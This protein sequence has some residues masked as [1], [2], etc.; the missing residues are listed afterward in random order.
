MAIRL[1]LIASLV[2]FLVVSYNSFADTPISG[3]VSGTWT[4][5]KSPYVLTGTVTIPANQTLTIEPGVLVEMPT[6]SQNLDVF[7]TLIAQGTATDSI[8]FRGVGGGG[9]VNSTHG[10]GIFFKAG[11]GAS[12]MQY[13]AIDKLGDNYFGNA[14]INITIPQTPTLQHISV[15]NS[16]QYDVLMW[17]GG[18]NNFADVRSA[19]T[20]ITVG[21]GALDARM[22]KLGP[23][24]F[25]RFINT[26]TVDK[27]YK[28][29]IE[30]GVLVEMPTWSQNLDV[31]G[32]LIAQGTATDSIRFR[33]VGGGGNVNSTHGGGI[34]FKTGGG[35][36]VMQYVAIDK[37]GDNYFGNAAI[38]ITIPQTPTLQHISV[39]NSE[40]YD[41][42]MWV[43]G[44][45][46]FA[47]V[48]SALTGVNNSAGALDARM[49]KLGPNSFY[50]FINTVTVDKGYKLTIEP[51][52]LVEMPTWSQN[53]D[54]FG[55]LIAQGTA[56]DSIRFR[57]VGGGGNVNSTHGGGIY[58]KAG[59]GA[60]VMQYVAIDKLGDNYFGNAAININ[61]A[62]TIR[63]CLIKNAEQ[64]AIIIN[65]ATISPT[66]QGN[67]F[68]ANSIAIRASAGNCNNIFNNTNAVISINNSSLAANA[69]WPIPGYKSY[70]LL[71]GAVTVPQAYI[72]T[73]APG[74][75]VDFGLQGGEIYVNGTLRAIGTESTPIR[76][77]RLQSTTASISGGRIYLSANSTNSALNLINLDKLGS[78]RDNNAALDIATANFSIGNITISN[79]QYR[80]LQLSNV[81]SAVISGSNF[82][83]NK[84][85]VYVSSGRPVFTNCNIYGNSDFGINNVS[86]ATADTVD[87]RNVYWGSELGPFHAS[88]NPTGKGN[89]V[90]NKVKFNPWKR[91]PQNGQIADIGICALV[92]P[93][94]DCNHTSA[95]NVTVR[96]RN[97]GNISQ[98]NFSVSYQI[99][100]GQPVTET[101]SST[102]L[103]PGETLDYTFTQKA[104]LSTIGSYTISTYSSFLADTFRL[105]DTIKVTIQHLPGVVA[106][107]NL[108]PVTNTE[109]LDIPVK[110]SWAAVTGALA[111]DLYVWKADATVPTQ[112]LVSNLSQIAYSLS[113]NNLQYGVAYKW[114]VV[115][116]QVSCRAE[117]AIL[118]F[119]TRL[120]ADLIV[121]S[122]NVP[123]AATSETDIVIRWRVKNQGT[124]ATQDKT[125]LDQVYLCD[126]PVLNTGS[127]NFYVNSISNLRALN[128]G[129]SYPSDELRYRL[130]QGIEGKYY[131]IVQ[132]NASNSVPEANKTNNQLVSSPISVSL[133]PPP[134]LQITSLVT[135]AN[136][137]SDDSTSVTYTIK[138][139]GTGP[140][141]VA[142]WVDQIFL[143]QNQALDVTTDKL[144]FS[145]ERN[146]ALPVNGEYIVS[147]KF[148]MPVRLTTGPYYIHV[149][150]DQLNQVFEY[151]KE[152]N[153]SRTNAINI[154]QKPTPNLVIHGL[155]VPSDT[156][157]TRQPIMVQWTTANEG[158]IATATSWL[159]TIYLSVDTVF[160]T[161][162]DKLL[163]SLLRTNAL[164]SLSSSSTQQSVTIPAST[165]EG[166]YYLF[167]RTDATDQIYES[168]GEQDNVAR[169]S[170]PV[171]VVLPDLIPTLLTAPASATS[172]QTIAVQ[173]KVKNDSRAGIYNT[174]WKDKLYLSTNST[175][176]PATDR[177]LTSVSANQLLAYGSEY[178]KQISTALPTGISGTYFLLLVSDADSNLVEKS[179]T[180]NVR[181]FSF[182][183]TLAPA[184]DL[185]VI[186]IVA[187][188]TDTL[189]TTLTLQYSV[190]NNGT[191]QIDN[192]TWQDSIYLSPTNTLSKANRI[193]LGT[194]YQ[195][196]SLTSGQS[197][198]QSAAFSIPTSISPG[199][200]FVAVKTDADSSIFEN[201]AETNNTTVATTA[202]N[203]V[204]PPSVDLAATAG[205]ILTTNATAGQPIT[206]QW[207]VK[208]NS[209][210][211]TVVSSWQD[212]IY[213]SANPVVD[214]ND[215]LL[216]TVDITKPLAAGTSY[217]RT[218]TVT[219]PPTSTGV[220]YVLIQTDKDNQNFDTQ[221][222]NN[223]LILSNA[224]S[225]GQ[226]ISIITPPPAD[227]VPISLFGPAEGMVSQPVS[228]SFTVRN[229]GTGPTPASNW[230]DQL[231][232]STDLTLGNDIQIGSFPHTGA[233]APGAEYMVTNQ[234]TLP[235]NVSGNYILL[236]K[237]DAGNAVFERNNEDNN[238]A[239]T[240]LAIIP[241]QPSD[242]VVSEVTIPTTERYAGSNSTITWKLSNIGPNAVNG[243]LREAVYLSKDS[244]LDAS[245][246][247]FGT[248]D[249]TV[250]LPSR[251]TQSRMLNKPLAD[252][253][254]GEYVVIVK[255]DVQNNIIEQNESNNEGVSVGK[256]KITVK[257]LVLNTL[258]TDTLIS[259]A[260]LYYRLNIPA[261]LVGETLAITLKGDSVKNA[262]NR[263]F[264]RKD[265]LPTANQY[266][267]LAA[268]P[269]KAN[270]TLI[271]PSLQ[272]GTYYL[273]GLGLDT[274]K[275]RQPV[276]LLARIIPFGISA[277]DAKEGGNTGLVTVKITGARFD[278]TTLFRLRKS[279][280]DLI[281]PYKVQLMDQ[282]LA[283]VTFDLQNKSLGIY[284]VVAEKPGSQTTVLATSFTIKLGPGNSQAANGNGGPAYG[285]GFICNITND[286]LDQQLTADFVTPAAI[287]FAT[288][289]TFT[290][291]FKNEGS[292]DIPVPTRFLIATSEGA[293]LAFT[294]D[295]LSENK[296]DL[297][298]VC[299]EENGPPGILRPGASGYFKIYTVSRTRGIL[300][301]DLLLTE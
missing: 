26:V 223:T 102:A 254:L 232:L 252:V 77:T 108:I 49:P 193:Y 21:A 150:T 199:R 127:D 281:T 202:T 130:P 44:A 272:A 33:G 80:G 4:K 192:K 158:A 35:A 71:I 246:M 233:L 171:R 18:A 256:L 8:R 279:G 234:F 212:A 3:S 75:L 155:T 261:N 31:F 292:V 142:K 170:T 32:T 168:P 149:L 28:L 17:V 262:V 84:V 114:K 182:A 98:S 276:S 38:N 156:V 200:Y 78:T 282:T 92:A 288:V 185:Q 15:R 271:I 63:N 273:L 2:Y 86:N 24:S 220:L 195:N 222:G 221:R 14:A 297:I 6:W 23:N 183:I 257:E 56:T 215:V 259:N 66:I 176:E 117:S 280:A 270:Q 287:R 109:N 110:L 225:S 121:E 194:V 16:E 25:Y 224:G 88:L 134:D 207:T 64:V 123:A 184:P 140:T 54:V 217:T 1:K 20:G 211:A 298:L 27:G 95:D 148:K 174:N 164:Q 93:I 253:G 124:G 128:I 218:Q 214:A 34:Y 263:I 115:A 286:G 30:P 196:R 82:F 47:D 177:L 160:N 289:G 50:R 100:K 69:S 206:I 169:L 247:L 152:G 209:A 104:N 243:Y 191:G 90:S 51:G 133:A 103:S 190:K 43:G 74:T 231:Y 126:Q 296:T 264:I 97:Y 120:Q 141:T 60:S 67:L 186:S 106:P 265:T 57:G 188:A 136:A 291:Y 181:S 290:V 12:V 96:I 267:Y 277:V 151:N 112:P 301:I 180:N 53:L 154:I 72:L 159:E 125:W 138:N 39:R 132:T 162:T 122:I 258:T 229:N 294:A 145:R 143:S 249:G 68:L 283:Y 111:Y 250:Y 179:K 144:L 203:L 241:Q 65:E 260:P 22:P 41:V 87:A 107:V 116:K 42:L 235:A 248:L 73:I 178:T 269:F 157:A 19:L 284:D 89:T 139:M 255:T 227:L 172:D 146:Q 101:V 163:G 36:S 113:N 161:A 85:G 230:V 266:T 11:G 61:L 119:T 137:I 293:A 236:L 300:S 238:I 208:N 46:N 165:T 187:P 226:P 5:A 299:Q 129:E 91:Q 70:Y 58:F 59:G 83:N 197:F 9:N 166:T 94:T 219:I 237:T 295:K 205:A 239:V 213:L 13:V 167:V 285:T 268:E 118:T 76:L 245:D 198:T 153:N 99:N 81:G 55:T 216:T 37:L 210:Q 275:T 131:I 40:Q 147:A 29:T 10:G 105:N 242:L 204:V 52:V 173:W 45:N 135:P 201:T 62:C 48:R 175:F 79:A 278:A 244:T 274:A 7:G 228:I 189:G 251:A 240:N